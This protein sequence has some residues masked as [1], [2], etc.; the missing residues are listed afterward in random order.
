M[1]L[2]LKRWCGPLYTIGKL[3]I[4]GKYFC[5]ILEDKNR[6]LNKKEGFDSGEIK[7]AG[8]TCIPFG[9]YQIVLYDSPHFKRILP[10]LLNVPDYSDIL[11]H[12]GNTVKDTRGCLLPGENKIKG[13]VINSR[14]YEDQLVI[15]ITKAIEAGEKVW[16]EI[17]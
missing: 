10:K 15:L 9:T 1:K 16:I 8:E 4:D 11:I 3:S 5:D 6:D 14:K 7:I 17:V 13:E 2:L 12:A